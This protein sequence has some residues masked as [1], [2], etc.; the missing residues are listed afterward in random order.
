MLVQEDW[1][2]L[3]SRKFGGNFF[4][5]KTTGETFVPSFQGEQPL[6]TQ[7][8]GKRMEEVDGGSRRRR[9]SHL[10]EPYAVNLAGMSN[11]NLTN[12]I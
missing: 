8:G 3:D 4:F 12:I 5:N 2:E 11:P 7:P 9:V 1:I 10:V 6:V